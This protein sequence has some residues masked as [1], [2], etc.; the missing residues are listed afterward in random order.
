MS[1][2]RKIMKNLE[3]FIKLPD[4]IVMKAYKLLI[5]SIFDTYLVKN[6]IIYAFY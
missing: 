3:E 6:D 4:Y 2:F 5:A 1:N